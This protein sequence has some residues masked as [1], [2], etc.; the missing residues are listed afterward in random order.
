MAATVENFLKESQALSCIHCGLCLG[1]CPTYLETG[2]ENDSPRG[3][4]YLMRALQAGRLPLEEKVVHHLDLC[5]GCRAC[6]SACPSGVPY[7][8]LLEGTRDFIERKHRRPAFARFLRKVIIEGLFPFPRRMRFAL[9][10]ARWIKSLRLEFLLPKFAREALELIPRFEASP[11]LPELSA[12]TAHCVKA[13]GFVEGCVMSVMF[14]TTN[15]NSVKLL[16]GQG[17]EVR[18]PRNQSCCGA[19]Y[20]HSG[21]LEK[22][23]ACAR[24]NIQ[25]FEEAQV[26][27]IVINA[28]GCG[29]TLK[30]Y[31]HLLE[32]DSLWAERAAAFSTKVR[33]LT[34]VLKPSTSPRPLAQRV[35]Y[36]DACHLAHAQRIGQQPRD[37]V[38]SIARNY[39]ELAESDL[40]CGSAGSYNLTEPAMADRLQKRKI[41]NILKS[42]AEI[43]VT[44]NPGCLLQIQAGL[45][46]AGARSVEVMHIADFLA[47]Y[48]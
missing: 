5:L 4:I 24:Q 25:A 29:S 36:H 39:V 14:G 47:K 48:Q 3:R 41:E 27:T 31:S 40:C 22:A 19:L 15:N 8:A 21:N 30:E 38:R 26:E 45:N 23:R 32:N 11:K 17:F 20:A 7:G 18:T 28:A 1:S 33:D 34:E 43:V 44:T 2:N 46:R 13:C 42:G 10:P 9:L 16:N 12:P 37:L 6:E 35:T